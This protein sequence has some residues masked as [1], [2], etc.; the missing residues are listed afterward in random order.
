MP[1]GAMLSDRIYSVDATEGLW[2]RRSL[3]RGSHSVL[4][5]PEKF[6]DLFWFLYNFTNA[7][8]S[9]PSSEVPHN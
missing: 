8:C 7:E 6:T 2:D 1:D 3:L 4:R 5:N 9:D